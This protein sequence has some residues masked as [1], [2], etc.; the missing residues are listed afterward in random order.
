MYPSDA[1]AQNYLGW[2]FV[3]PGGNDATCNTQVATVNSP[4]APPEAP[5]TVPCKTFT[6]ACTLLAAKGANWSIQAEPGNY[7]EN[8]KCNASGLDYANK[9]NI[10]GRRMGA[11]PSYLKGASASAP[12]WE[13]TGNHVYLNKIIFE[14]SPGDALYVHG[15]DSFHQ[16]N[17]V[18]IGYN[19]TFDKNGGV[20]VHANH[21][22][23]LI[24]Y[25]DNIYD[26][27]GSSCVL[28]ENSTYTS[29]SGTSI[30]NCGSATGVPVTPR[31]GVIVSK[32]YYTQYYGNLEQS[33]ASPNL[34]L[35]DSFEALVVQNATKGPFSYM[36]TSAQG[37]AEASYELSTDTICGN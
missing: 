17:D 13:M 31:P 22:Y 6:K 26:S 12:A 32:S 15:T 34:S 29:I 23:G 2:I 3:A 11:P 5:G 19:T 16:S 25:N 20:A 33:G 18:V 14:G 30:Y 27:G 4:I 21:S 28:I 37:A 7:I 24:L 8:V 9:A 1:N 36:V 10:V 35:V